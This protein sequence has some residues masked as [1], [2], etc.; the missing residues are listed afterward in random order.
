MRL[1]VSLAVF[2]LLAL[3]Q[4]SFACDSNGCLLATRGQAG[5]IK[6]GGFRLD[7]SYRMSSQTV[8]LNGREKTADVLRPK[9][10]LEEGVLLP[11]F[12]REIAGR[13]R[14]LQAELAYGASDRTNLFVSVPVAGERAYTVAH[15]LQ[16]SRYVYGGA[17]D[18]VLGVRQNLFAVAG[19]RVT[20]TLT[21]R[22]PTGRSNRLD[23]FDGTLLEPT[24]QPGAG[25]FDVTASLQYATSWPSARMTWSGSLSRQWNAVNRYEYRFGDETIL[26]VAA[27]WAASGRLGVSVQGKLFNKERSAF[28][29]VSVPSTGARYLYLNPGLRFRAGRRSAIYGVYQIPVYRRVNDTQLAPR[30]GLLLGASV[31]L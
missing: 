9:V 2:L 25:A 12:H 21:T 20:G 23:E 4:Q 19:N 26:G 18:V 22:V 6:K 5:F 17:G 7:A 30:R 14:F 10:Y 31:D 29:D 28:H 27:Q 8:G 15:G 24:M 11:A 16:S 13:E 3:S 1:A